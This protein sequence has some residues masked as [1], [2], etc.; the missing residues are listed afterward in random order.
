MSREKLQIRGSGII[1]NQD[2]GFI[3]GN[4]TDED[5]NTGTWFV[6]KLKSPSQVAAQKSIS[7]H[8]ISSENTVSAPLAPKPVTTKPNDDFKPN[9]T[10]ALSG[11]ITGLFFTKWST[12]VKTASF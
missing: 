12:T 9:T 10:G 2:G 3:H 5:E 11:L 1:S 4:Y 6:T 8:D 7:N